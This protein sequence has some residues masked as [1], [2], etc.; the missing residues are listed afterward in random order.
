MA[1]PPGQRLHRCAGES[2]TQGS[3]L[4]FD[5]HITMTV[6][7]VVLKFLTNLFLLHCYEVTND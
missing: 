4:L 2:F 6:F 1:E 7:Y 3:S 5:Q